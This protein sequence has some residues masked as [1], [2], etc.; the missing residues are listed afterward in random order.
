MCRDEFPPCDLIISG[1]T[2]NS[3]KP[4]DSEESDSLMATN[5]IISTRVAHLGIID[6]TL[7]VPYSY[8]H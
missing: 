1:V 5:K 2:V 4:N 3:T 7:E 8:S 6:E